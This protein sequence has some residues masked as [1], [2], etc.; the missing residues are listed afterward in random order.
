MFWSHEDAPSNVQH[1][2]SCYLSDPDTRILLENTSAVACSRRGMSRHYS[3]GKYN[4]YTYIINPDFQFRS[5]LSSGNGYIH[6]SSNTSHTVGHQ[7]VHRA[8]AAAQRRRSLRSRKCSS[9]SSVPSRR[10]SRQDSFGLDKFM[11]TLNDNTT[12]G[13][14]SNN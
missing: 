2:C 5:V 12:D 13:K 1:Q 10:N 11:A 6:Y 3:D 8:G 7:L 4:N 9:A 14:Q